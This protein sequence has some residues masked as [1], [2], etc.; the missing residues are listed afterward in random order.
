MR[1][2]PIV[3]NRY[4]VTTNTWTSIPDMHTARSGAGAAALGEKVY[5]VGDKIVLFTTPRW[6]V[7]TQQRENGIRVQV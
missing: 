5:V 3:T 6:N 1:L 4:D 7:M 2:H